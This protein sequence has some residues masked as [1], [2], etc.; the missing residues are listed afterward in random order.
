M[1]AVASAG[2]TA[3]ASATLN[4]TQSAVSRALL[5]AEEK[6][7]VRLFERTPR[8]LV[9]TAA[10]DRLIQGAGAVLASLTDLEASVRAP[11][12]S[13][14]R[15]RVVCEC[16]TAYRWMPSALL[17]L[18]ERLPNLEVTLAVDHTADP[19][20]ALVAGEIDI[21]LLTTSPTRGAIEE[22]PLFSD[23]I[24]FVVS[25]SHPLAARAAVTA[26]DLRAYTI[27]TSN[28]PPA[29]AA[30]FAGRVF[31]RRPPANRPMILPLTEAVIDAARAGMGVAVLSEWIAT[32]YLGHGDL[33]AKRFGAGPLQRPWRIA[34][35]PEAAEAAR[36]LAGALE[37]SAPRVYPSARPALRSA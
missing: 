13:P 11:A 5:L 7:G 33:V 2:S 24:V 1:L 9:P 32:S 3:G 14:T 8:G 23:E 20:G 28:T 10:G 34:Y 35:R 30:W 29:E 4:L 19:V 37:G 25:T 12:P 27:I 22:R 17:K 26:K 21:A 15:V 18:R 31:G 16:Y 36:R 6:L